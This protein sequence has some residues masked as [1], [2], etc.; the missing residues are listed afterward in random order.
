MRKLFTY[1]NE[2][3]ALAIITQIDEP[4]HQF[5]IIEQVLE[6]TYEHEKFNLP[7]KSMN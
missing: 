3:G 2:T 7:L 4:P 5:F 1:L 6:L